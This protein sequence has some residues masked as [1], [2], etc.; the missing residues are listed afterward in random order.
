M[1]IFNISYASE[2]NPMSWNEIRNKY[3]YYVNLIENYSDENILFELSN[4][5]HILPINMDECIKSRAVIFMTG[6]RN[7]QSAREILKEIIVRGKNSPNFS[8][9]G[10]TPEITLMSEA[11]IALVR[12]DLNNEMSKSNIINDDGKEDYLINK[13]QDK[14]LVKDALKFEPTCVQLF[15]LLHQMVPVPKLMKIVETG[16]DKMKDH[17]LGALEISGDNSI[18]DKIIEIINKIDL[19]Y[20]KNKALDNVELHK[21]AKLFRCQRILSNIGDKKA[22][23][24]LKNNLQNPDPAVRHHTAME[25]FKFKERGILSKK[26]I[27]DDL[28]KLSKDKSKPISEDIK[29]YLKKN[30]LIKN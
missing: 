10:F 3:T 30:K 7:I 25:I 22:Y 20:D 13:I 18:Q 24:L 21:R 12:L 17:A 9:T 23:D 5:S 14:C 28:L 4:I 11:K 26:E 8:S 27:D 29:N 2:I 1:V 6:K 16:N 19:N 15:E